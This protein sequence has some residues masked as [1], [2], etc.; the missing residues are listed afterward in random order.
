MHSIANAPGED[1]AGSRPWVW[2]LLAMFLA[3]TDL[4]VHLFRGMVAFDE[5]ALNLA[6]QLVREGKWPHRDFTDI[7]SGGL[8]VFD[9]LMQALLGEDLRAIR[10]PLGIATVAWVGLVTAVLRRFVTPP[11][12]AGIAFLAYLWGPPLYTAAMPT[13][14]LLYLATALIWCL[15][16]WHETDDAR[17]WGAAG[18]AI[19][20]GFLLK[21]NALFLLAGAGCALLTDDRHRSGLLGGLVVAL[22]ALGAAATVSRGWTP[23][24]AA[25]LYLPILLL[26]GTALHHQWRTHRSLAFDAAAISRPLFWLAGGTAAVLL[27]WVLA[28]AATGGL[29]ALIDGVLVLPL[30]RALWARFIPP[31]WW[32]PDLLVVALLAVMLFRRWS[33]PGAQAVGILAVGLALVLSDRAQMDT[34]LLVESV[35][36]EIRIVGA[37]ALAAVALGRW[38]EPGPRFRPVLLVGWI[39]AWFALMQY[40]YGSPNY[41]SYVAPLLILA[42]TAAVAHHVPRPVGGGLVL[43]LGIWTVSVDHGQPLTNMGFA[44]LSPPGVNFRLDL[45]RGGLLVYAHD[46]VGYEAIVGTLDRWGAERIIAGPDS[47]EIYYFSG[48]PFEDREFFEFMAPEWSTEVFLRRI[49]E[50]R[51]DALVL[52]TRPFFSKFAADSV[53]AALPVRP[54]ADTT[55][56]RFRLLRLAPG[57]ASP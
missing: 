23:T 14:Y 29:H 51:P 9:A 17:W 2:A 57:H 4:S 35:W 11:V 53:L 13:W 52:N 45:P 46:K 39:A 36:R 1:G 34:G 12:A 40:P 54:L 30:R 41:V 26:A 31:G 27:P 55:I 19:G 33:T 7:Y 42:G 16:R 25:T 50:R 22:G 10:V 49:V 28:Y 32:L 3:A 44:H 8:A 20:L 24:S 38:R 15:L 43:A 56:G 37:G 6:A 48:R 21:I 18:L 5:G 47:P